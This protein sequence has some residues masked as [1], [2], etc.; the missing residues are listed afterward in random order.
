MSDGFGLLHADGASLG[1]PGPGGAGA[2]IYDETGRL[3]EEIS[4]SLGPAV[5]NNEAE[6]QSLLFGLERL[7]ALGA[8]K[9]RI[10]MDSEL[11]V[12]QVLG[13]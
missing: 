7:R 5:T 6:Y 3:A 4:E 10:R 12:R 8:R 11:V 1:N 13:V 2:A 9:V